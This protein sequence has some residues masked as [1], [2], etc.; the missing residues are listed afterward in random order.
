ME[1]KRDFVEKKGT[2]R[3]C[4]RQGFRQ[5]YD[6][7]FKILV[8]REAMNI[9]NLAASRKFNVPEN[10]IRRWS[11][12]LDKLKGAHSTRKAFRGPKTGRFTELESKDVQ[13]V[14]AKRELGYPISIEAIMMKAVEIRNTLLIPD[15]VFKVSYGWCRRMMKRNNLC[16]RRQTTLAKKLPKDYEEKLSGY[17]DSVCSLR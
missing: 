12:Q 16:L 3:T 1:K 6:A 14:Q 15:D 11:Q 17:S 13:F 7:N 4:P 10:N 5:S 9:G 8:S 2:Q